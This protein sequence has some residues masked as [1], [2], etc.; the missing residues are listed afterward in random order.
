[1]RSAPLDFLNCFSGVQTT[2][3]VREQGSSLILIAPRWPSKHWVAEIIQL[4]ADEPWPLPI[5]R[6]L[7]SQAGGEIYHP[8]PDRIALWAWP[9]RGGT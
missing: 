3:R 6:D 8:H 5:R 7:L 2:I 1:M 9:V 4:L